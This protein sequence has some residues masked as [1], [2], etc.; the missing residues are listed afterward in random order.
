MNFLARLL[1]REEPGDAPDRLLAGEIMERLLLL[2]PQLRLVRRHAARLQPAIEVAIRH[3]NGIVAGVPPA[4]E[5]SAAVWSNDPYIHAFFAAPDD[6][7]RA[8]SRSADLRAFFEQQPDVDEAYAVLGMAMTEKHTLGVALEGQTMRRDVRQTIVSFSDHQVRICGRT[9]PQ[10]RREIVRRLVD[11]LGL[12]GLVR[13]AAGKSRRDL[14]EQER[15]LL[16]TR[17][18]IL[19]RQGVGLRSVLGQEAGPGAEEVAELQE[20]IADNARRLAS[21]GVKSEALE[22]ELEQLCA[23][24]SEPGP[25]IYV[26]SKQ[27]RLDRMNVVLPDNRT[28]GGCALTIQVARIPTTP[29]QLRAFALVRFARAELLPAVSLL[30]E[31][32][33]LLG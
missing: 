32:S 11:Q 3:M 25:H 13:I 30:D 5:A 1:G 17:V 24:L 12:D 15:A 33:R 16:R 9:E 7:A 19:E 27:F 6:V 29:P 20:Q 22:R 14:L 8:L 23:V 4:R 18:Q 26:E 31:A 10:L 28:E 2:N 21:L